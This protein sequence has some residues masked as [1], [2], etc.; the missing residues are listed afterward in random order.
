MMTARDEVSMDIAIRFW[1]KVDG[2]GGVTSCWE[3]RGTRQPTGYGTFT[4]PDGDGHKSAA[5]HR[6]AWE[7]VYGEIPDGLFVC[8]HCDNPPCVN[9]AHL[10]L[11]THADNMRDA[12]SKGRLRGGRNKFEFGDRCK[13]GHERTPENTYVQPK[14][15]GR[16]CIPCRVNNTRK[17]RAKRIN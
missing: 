3:W 2:T 4:T 5:A 10:F 1:T 8:H 14:T 11:G 13:Y 9:P 17:Q 15:G 6:L 12:A 16:S 7:F